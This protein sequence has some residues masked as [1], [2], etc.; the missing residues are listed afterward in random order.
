MKSLVENIESQIATDKEV[1]TVLPR[2]GIKAIKTLV[3]TI[4]ET[5]QKYEKANELV[6][7]A[8]YVGYERCAD[9]A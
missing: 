1:I 8:I 7:G 9:P 4:E 6:I 3:K 2:N 5:T